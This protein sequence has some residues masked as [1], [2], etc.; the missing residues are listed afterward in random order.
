MILLIEQHQLKLDELCRRLKVR[1]LS[2]PASSCMNNEALKMT[3][4][5]AAAKSVFVPG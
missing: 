2:P 4:K 3:A 5:W 1:R